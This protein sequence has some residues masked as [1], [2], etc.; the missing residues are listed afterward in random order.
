MIVNTSPWMSDTSDMVDHPELMTKH[1]E[2]MQDTNYDILFDSG[3]IFPRDVYV[4]PVSPMF[5]SAKS[6]LSDDFVFNIPLD[7][8]Y[9]I[10]AGDCDLVWDMTFEMYN[11]DVMSWVRHEMGEVWTSRSREFMTNT[12]HKLGLH[13]D[14]V[15]VALNNREW[16]LHEC[17]FAKTITVNKC[18]AWYYPEI[19]RKYQDEQISKYHKGQRFRN[20]FITTLGELRLHKTQLARR[21]YHNPQRWLVSARQS[22]WDLKVN[23]ELELPWHLDPHAWGERYTHYRKI[24]PELMTVMS[25]AMID[26]VCDTIMLSTPLSPTGQTTEKPY[27]SITMLKPFI[28]LGTHLG[29]Q[30]LRD[31]GFKT[32]HNF[33][34]EDYDSITDPEQRYHRVCDI[35]H[36]I[37]SDSHFGQKLC[38]I[39]KILIHNYEHYKTLITSKNH[40]RYSYD[41][42]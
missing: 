4:H 25:E 35:L 33:W 12:Q 8:V 9:R 2:K 20:D 23:T 18:D 16:Q 6:G 19:C 27:R 17:E 26:V 39:E 38:G 21:I 10:Q 32:F 36:N 40:L 41:S 24:K 15:W 11:P 34:P 30:Y 3:S 14:Q 1:L 5:T 29:L 42:H 13:K 28:Y 31:Q 37:S 7:I 22:E